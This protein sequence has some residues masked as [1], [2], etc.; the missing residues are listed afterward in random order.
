MTIILNLTDEYYN[1]W[2]F[3]EVDQAENV[4]YFKTHVF[5]QHVSI[6]IFT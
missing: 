6:L 3:F 5:L 2:N 4:A 1:F